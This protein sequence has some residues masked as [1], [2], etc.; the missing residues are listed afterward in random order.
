MLDVGDTVVQGK[1]ARHISCN[2]W[3]LSWTE[4]LYQIYLFIYYYFLYPYVLIVEEPQLLSMLS[5]HQVKRC[6]VAFLLVARPCCLATLYTDSSFTLKSMW[7]IF[8]SVL[9]NPIFMV[10]TDQIL[11]EC[12]GHWCLC[13]TLLSFY[14][15][16]GLVNPHPVAPGL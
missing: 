16:Y 13:L 6:K 1:A 15:K 11:Y 10:E 12:D 7:Q 14:L 4:S 8:Y 2:N 3:S 5:F 9:Y